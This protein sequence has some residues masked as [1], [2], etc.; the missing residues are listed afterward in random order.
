[1]F[2]LTCVRPE[3]TRRA[4]MQEVAKIC[5]GKPLRSSGVNTS[6]MRIT[7]QTTVQDE[8]SP[9]LKHECDDG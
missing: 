4:W 6:S 5:C 7:R 2:L 9:K 3:N 8:P 1:M